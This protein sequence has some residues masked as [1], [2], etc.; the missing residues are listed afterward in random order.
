VRGQRTGAHVAAAAVAL[1]TLSCTHPQRPEI[2]TDASAET[3]NVF[4]VDGAGARG[5]YGNYGYVLYLATDP[6]QQRCLDIV[7]SDGSLAAALDQIAE[8]TD[9]TYSPFTYSG[10]P[11]RVALKADETRE[12][13]DASYQYF[14]GE[15]LISS[16][17]FYYTGSHQVFLN[18]PDQL[19]W[20]I[21]EVVD[22]ALE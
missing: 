17:A 6:D 16:S 22:I 11:F 21:Y 18:C 8:N 2:V 13:H 5:A 19:R 7:V 14:D 15:I 20:Q 12:I 1:A 9:W 4:W 10:K 3:S